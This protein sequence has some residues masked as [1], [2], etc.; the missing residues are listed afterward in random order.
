MLAGAILMLLSGT[1]GL[2]V[3]AEVILAIGMG[4]TN[5]AVFK[6]VAQEVP[7]ARNNFV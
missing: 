5:A 2:S 7:E 1:F 4:V 6:L 3:V